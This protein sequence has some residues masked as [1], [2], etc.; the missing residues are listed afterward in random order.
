[1]LETVLVTG[2]GGF[3]GRA[4]LPHL[5]ASGFEVRSH[6][7]SQGDLSVALPACDGVGH[8][9]H[10]AGKTFVPD[11]WEDPARFYRD[12]TMSTAHVLDYCRQTGARLVYVSAYVYGIPQQLPIPETHPL[13]PSSP[14]AHSKI[15]AEDLV[16]F[17]Q[18]QFGVAATII[19]PFNLYGPGQGPRFLIPSIVRQ[20]LDPALSTITLASLTPRR[21]YLHVTDFVSLVVAVVRAA[22]GGVYNA[23]SGESIAV[24]DLADLVRELALTSKPIRTSGEDRRNE[25]PDTVADIRRAS[26]D[27]GWEPQVTLRDGLRHTI[28]GVMRDTPAR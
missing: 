11:S 21:D 17:Y 3:V 18:R 8:V 24:A 15:L 12:N 2:A 28:A 26:A 1:M 20:A 4:L 9:V 23:G 5:R 13:D 7:R 19:R 10:L 16:R 25:I 22:P 14:Y 6:A 27:L